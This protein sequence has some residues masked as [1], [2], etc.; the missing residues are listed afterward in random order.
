MTK[1]PQAEPYGNIPEA[2]YANYLQVGYNPYEFL[3]AFGQ[4]HDGEESVIH[5]VLV[6]HPVYA[7]EFLGVLANALA[8]Y[9]SAYGPIPRCDAKLGRSNPETLG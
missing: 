7:K 9:E 8:E 5:S 3:V 1:A 4:S 6:A 2:K